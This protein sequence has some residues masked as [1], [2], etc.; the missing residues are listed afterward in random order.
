MTA[1]P[2][3]RSLLFV[4]GGPDI[5][6]EIFQSGAIAAYAAREAMAKPNPSE[7]RLAPITLSQTIH[8]IYLISPV[9]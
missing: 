1:A 2:A 9:K 7:Y 3:R 4:R 8:V 6:R 5:Q